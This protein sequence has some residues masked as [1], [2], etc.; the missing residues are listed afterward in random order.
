MLKACAVISVMFVVMSLIWMS[1]LIL[2]LRLM[3]RFYALNRLSTTLL[4]RWCLLKLIRSGRRFVRVG[5][6]MLLI[7]CLV[8]LRKL[9]CV[10][11]FVILIGVL[12]RWRRV[13][14][15]I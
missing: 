7:L 6:L 12:W 11:L 4:I 2:L 5:V 9:S 8:R 1:L 3:V 14:L 10:L 13:G 15:I